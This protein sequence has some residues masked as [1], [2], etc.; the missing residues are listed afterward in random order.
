MP[1]TRSKALALAV[2]LTACVSAPAVTTASPTPS[3]EAGPIATPIPTT[4]AAGNCYPTD[5][6]QYVYHPAR[7]QVLAACIRVAGTVV[8]VLREADGDDHIRVEP[9]AAF[10]NLL[11]PAN[12]N[13]AGCLN[14]CLVVEPV[15]E[16]AVT[17]VDAI[18]TCAADTDPLVSLPTAGQHIW[19][20]GRYVLDLQHGGWAELHPLY[21]WGVN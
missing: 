18:A 4:A 16:N 8:R 12:V 20:E 17:Q 6:D 2:L 21:R 5:Q 13:Q 7:L 11:R 1:A 10:A 9:D 14:G 15:C 3:D 19:L